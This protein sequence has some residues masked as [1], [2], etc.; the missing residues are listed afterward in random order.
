MFSITDKTTDILS[1]EEL[2]DA[3][4]RDSISVAS[5]DSFVSAAEVRGTLASSRN[6][7]VLVI[8]LA[9]KELF[10]CS[11]L[12]SSVIVWFYERHLRFHTSYLYVYSVALLAAAPKTIPPGDE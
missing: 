5:T 4:V 1:R 10:I 7:Y 9:S 8:F 3:G 2:D 12:F 6:V 11:T